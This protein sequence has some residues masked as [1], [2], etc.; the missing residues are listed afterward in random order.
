MPLEL[1]LGPLRRGRCVGSLEQDQRDQTK[2]QRLREARRLVCERE[3]LL[4]GQIL[5]STSSAE[6]ARTQRSMGIEDATYL[7]LECSPSDFPAALI[8]IFGTFYMS[9]TCPVTGFDALIEGG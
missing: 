4:L 3:P 2:A 7:W 9:H 5:Y 1:A 6:L 8:N